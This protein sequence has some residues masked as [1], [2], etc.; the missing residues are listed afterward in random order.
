MDRG[1][2]RTN[3]RQADEGVRPAPQFVGDCSRSSIDDETG[4]PRRS[5][6][7]TS[8]RKSPSPKT[9]NVLQPIK[10]TTRSKGYED[11][12]AGLTSVG[13]IP[14]VRSPCMTQRCR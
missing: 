5:S 2:S 3:I 9:A 12:R 11:H 4:T 6:A 7:S 1:K 13:Q 14:T 8:E 10:Q